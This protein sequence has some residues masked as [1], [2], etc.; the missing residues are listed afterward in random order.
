ME[1]PEGW[2]QKYDRVGVGGGAA[3]EGNGINKGAGGKEA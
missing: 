2:H 3:A 1:V